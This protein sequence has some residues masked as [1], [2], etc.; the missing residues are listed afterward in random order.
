M[1]QAW[2]RVVRG[3]CKWQCDC[4]DTATLQRLRLSPLSIHLAA[5]LALASGKRY[6]LGC[7][8]YRPGRRE[9]RQGQRPV[10]VSGEEGGAPCA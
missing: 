9:E 10:G 7:E 6:R 8:R 5:E 2:V 4:R 1:I 3:T